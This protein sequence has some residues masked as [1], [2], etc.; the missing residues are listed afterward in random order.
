MREAVSVRGGLVLP[1]SHQVHA[2]TGMAV[3]SEKRADSLPASLQ[4]EVL[5]TAAHVGGMPYLLNT[6]REI[7]GAA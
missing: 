2:A 6:L 1:Q 5:K 7:R 3:P 4:A